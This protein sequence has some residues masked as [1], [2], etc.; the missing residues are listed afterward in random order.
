MPFTYRKQHTYDMQTA[1]L[2][3]VNGILINIIHNP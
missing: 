2:R 1:Y 3:Y